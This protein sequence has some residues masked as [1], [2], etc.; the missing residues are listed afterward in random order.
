MCFGQITC[1]DSAIRSIMLLH[2]ED[3]RPFD[4]HGKEGVDMIVQMDTVG[5]EKP[6]RDS[7]VVPEN[8]IPRG[9]AR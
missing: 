4:T 5:C 1:C 7:L 2:R 9:F 8:P 3:M 6:G